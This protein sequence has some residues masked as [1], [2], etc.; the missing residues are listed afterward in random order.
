[1]IARG[2]VRRVP[3]TGVF[4]ARLTRDIP[5]Q[6]QLPLV[7]LDKRGAIVLQQGVTVIRQ[8]PPE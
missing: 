5:W 2:D 4:V 3:G 1:V 7:G 6:G 8:A